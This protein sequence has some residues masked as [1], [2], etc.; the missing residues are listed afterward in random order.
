M[1]TQQQL[2]IV[3]H[4]EQYH[5]HSEEAN[6]RALTALILAGWGHVP[7][8]Q[9]PPGVLEAAYLGRPIKER[10]NDPHPW[11]NRQELTDEEREVIEARLAR[12]RAAATWRYQRR[13]QHQGDL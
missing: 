5:R 2:Q 3:A 8:A 10:G 9:I 12:E 11:A 1:T 6:M 7:R 13:R 4:D